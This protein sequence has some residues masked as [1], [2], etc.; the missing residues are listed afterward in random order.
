MLC[1]TWP[2]NI[3]QQLLACCWARPLSPP[4]LIVRHQCSHVSTSHCNNNYQ[5]SE[6]ENLGLSWNHVVLRSDWHWH[7]IWSWIS[8]SLKS[9]QLVFIGSSNCDVCG[10]HWIQSQRQRWSMASILLTSTTVMYN[11]RLRLTSY[12]VSWVRLHV[13]LVIRESSNCDR[14]L[15]QLMHVDLHWLDMPVW[16]KFKLVSMVHNCLH[17]KAPR[18]LTGWGYCIRISDVASLLNKPLLVHGSAVSFCY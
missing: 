16:V 12:S 4:L 1:V 17:H 6:C 13:L 8:T 10:D 18:Y 14:G 7:R 3:T 15:R 11:W 5:T 2:G 9:A